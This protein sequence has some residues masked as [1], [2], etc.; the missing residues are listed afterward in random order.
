MFVII[1][2]E[3]IWQFWQYANYWFVCTYTGKP[4]YVFMIHR[5]IYTHV[6]GIVPHCTHLCYIFLLAIDY[7][8]RSM[9]KIEVLSLAALH[10]TE[11]THRQ[12]TKFSK[13]VCLIGI[14]LF[15]FADT[16]TNSPSTSA[17]SDHWFYGCLLL[18]MMKKPQEMYVFLDIYPM[19]VYFLC[20]FGLV[21]VF[22]P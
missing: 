7:E 4:I 2:I 13:K 14:W 17:W 8:N 9:K 11:H 12:I 1:I 22:K 6:D 16:C 10:N 21:S 15:F 18:M 20:A 19:D 3:S 5:C